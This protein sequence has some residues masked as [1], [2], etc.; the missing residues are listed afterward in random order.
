MSPA[1]M[2]WTALPLPLAHGLNS[3]DLLSLF[4]HFLLL[5]MLAIGGAI[6]TSAD[7]N[8]FIVQ[9]HAWISDA[10][11]TASIA[12][13]Q[14]APGPNILFVAVLGWN[15]AGPLGALATMAGIMLPSTTLALAAT[16]WGRARQESVGVR[17]FTNGMAPLTLGLLLATGWVLSQ[18]FRDSVG[19]TLLV[20]LTVLAML[21]TRLSPMWLIAVGAVVG[22]LGWA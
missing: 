14:A 12:I 11:F 4:G 8:R 1:A 20:L 2:G 21:R 13:A 16:R 19:A 6:T 3:L 22:L 9:E 15:V 10:Q 7:M 5:S 17:A 18:P